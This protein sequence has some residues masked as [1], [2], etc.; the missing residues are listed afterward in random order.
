M[1]GLIYKLM[2]MGARKDNY[3]FFVEIG[4]HPIFL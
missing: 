2:G 1:D 4:L 3:A